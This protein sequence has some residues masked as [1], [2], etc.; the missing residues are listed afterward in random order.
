MLAENYIQNQKYRTQVHTMSFIEN[1]KKLKKEKGY[2][3]NELSKMCGIPLG[4]LSKLF[5]GI[6]EE[7][8]LSAALAIAKALDTTVDSLTE[9]NEGTYTTEERDLIQKYRKLDIHG[10]NLAELIIK[11]E[12]TRVEAALQKAAESTPDPVENAKADTE[13]KK[14]ADAPAQI[15]QQNTDFSIRTLP[16]YSSPFAA[17]DE[18][19]RTENDNATIRVKNTGKVTE[20]SYALRV[21]G[22]SMLPDYADGD[23]LIIKEQSAV[24]D[25]EFGIFI[26]DNNA[27]FKKFTSDMLISLNPEYPA[28]PLS[29]FSEFACVG[30][31]LGRLKSKKN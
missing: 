7:P 18:N 24:S 4:T 6:I 20:A 31:V 25:G 16:L 27:Y 29:Q 23:I 30:L 22:D 10:K 15:P 19:Y 14:V 1:A 12:Y 28:L 2:T 11:N 21:V 17:I 26:C 5:S 8:K 13:E 3:T 9:T